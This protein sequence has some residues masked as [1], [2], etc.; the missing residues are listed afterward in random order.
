MNTAYRHTIS[1]KEEAGFALPSILFLITIL[2]LVALSVVMLHYLQRKAA[3]LDLA[4]V[5]AHY[6]AQS[7]IDEFLAQQTSLSHIDL[8]GTYEYSFS[9]NSK[10]TVTLSRWG[11]FFLVRSTGIC[12][13]VKINIIAAAADHPS[14]DFNNALIFANPNHQLVCAGTTTITGDVIAGKGGVI[15]GTL[16]GLPTPR[17][18]PVQGKIS[19]QANIQMPQFCTAELMNE[20]SAWD[21][22]LAA[23]NGGG[24]GDKTT[25]FFR[26]SPTILQPQLIAPSVSNVYINGDVIIQGQYVR[27][28]NPL[29]IA[30]SGSISFSDSARI[31]GLIKILAGKQIT[32]ASNVEFDFPV[33]YSQ[34]SIAIL[35]N[36]LRAQLFA[37]SLTFSSSAAARYPSAAVSIQLQ[38]SHPPK[39]QIIMENGSHLEGTMLFLAPAAD[40]AVVILKDGS[41]ITGSLYST[42]YITLD[43]SIDGTVITKEFYF[44]QSPTSYLGWLKS[45]RINRTALPKSYLVPPGF[46]DSPKLDVLDWL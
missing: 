45:A 34:I 35:S 44:Y 41:K 29:T 25:L 24:T 13:A 11:C 27:I 14:S 33:V 18:L 43:G 36:R 3:M 5:H 40:T 30:A 9:Y 15:T 4:K 20:L 23:A 32:I 2:S 8:N 42:A 46:S 37:P 6:A 26:G 21:Q 28:E 17:T 19:R 31:R 10:A 1:K 7:G 22:L 39:N 12:G 16:H 38:V